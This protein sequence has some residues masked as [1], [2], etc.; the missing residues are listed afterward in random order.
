V[1]RNNLLN[2]GNMQQTWFDAY[3]RTTLLPGLIA[4][5]VVNA[6]ML[7]VFYLD[8]VTM[9]PANGPDG[10]VYNYHY[11]MDSNGKIQFYSVVTFNADST[12]PPSSGDPAPDEPLMDE[13]VDLVSDPYNSNQTPAWGWVGYELGCYSGYLPS[14]PLAGDYYYS[15]DLS[16]YTY[17]MT[18]QTFFSWFFDQTPSIAAGKVIPTMGHSGNQPARG[19]STFVN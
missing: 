19:G 2:L 15:I 1:L 18:K 4:R 9:A 14:Y 10:A 16:G 5:G 11:G 17:T 8:T 3:V 13:L 12:T 7:P 6:E